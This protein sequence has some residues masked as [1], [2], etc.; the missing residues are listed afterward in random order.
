MWNNGLEKVGC[1]RTSG[2]K[3]RGWK[4][5]EMKRREETN[6]VTILGF[7]GSTAGAVKQ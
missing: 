7:G 4:K 3:G 2:E 1:G 6:K 5:L